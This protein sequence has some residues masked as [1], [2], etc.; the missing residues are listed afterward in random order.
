ML[1]QRT[2]LYLSTRNYKE[3]QRKRK[4]NNFNLSQTVNTFLEIQWFGDMSNNL[5]FELEETKKKLDKAN[6]QRSILET[7]MSDIQKLLDTKDERKN[8]ELTLFQHFQSNV[9]NRIENMEKTGYATDYE[10]LSGV[11]HR[12]FFPNNHLTMGIVKDIF[13]RVKNKSFDFDFFQQL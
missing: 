12:D 4:E 13:Y 1:E 8:K 3:Y 7:R 9:K 6:E 10:K 2:T 11:W 5:E